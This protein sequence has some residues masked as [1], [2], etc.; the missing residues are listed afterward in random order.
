VK[1]NKFDR[2]LR[3]MG[4]VGIAIGVVGLL[5]AMAT[6]G[7]VVEAA[8]AVAAGY[9]GGATTVYADTLSC[10]ADGGSLVSLDKAQEIVVAKG[11]ASINVYLY[12][13][14]GGVATGNTNGPANKN[15][16]VLIGS[17]TG[18]D[19]TTWNTKGGSGLYRCG[20]AGSAAEVVTLAGVQ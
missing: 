6:R 2:F 5:S 12:P 14:A 11:T 16:G 4:V 15:K 9:G 8:R 10:P 20:S 13:A 19:S 17:A 7:V 18:A 3:F 1:G